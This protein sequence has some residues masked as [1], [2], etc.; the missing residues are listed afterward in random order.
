[1]KRLIFLFLFT[2]ICFCGLEAQSVQMRVTGMILDDQ[3]TKECYTMNLEYICL[4]G[5]CDLLISSD[6][7]SVELNSGS[8]NSNWLPFSGTVCF[9]RKK[10]TYRSKFK[11]EVGKLASVVTGRDEVVRDGCVVV[12]EGG[13]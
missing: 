5:D 12:I 1:M 3:P 7:E 10:R 6:I 4:N 11:C 9:D 8:P 13:G 2:S